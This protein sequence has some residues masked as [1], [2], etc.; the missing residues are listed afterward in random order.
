MYSFTCRDRVGI[1][2]PGKGDTALNI[3]LAYH[4]RHSC[5]IAGHPFSLRFQVGFN[6]QLAFPLGFVL[7]RESSTDLNDI[8]EAPIGGLWD[9]TGALN[10]APQPGSTVALLSVNS[11]GRVQ[12]T[13]RPKAYIFCYHHTN[14]AQRRFISSTL[15]CP[16]F[17]ASDY[18]PEHGSVHDEGDV[19]FVSLEDLGAAFRKVDPDYLVTMLR[20]EEGSRDEARRVWMALIGDGWTV[21]HHTQLLA[22]P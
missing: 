11:A 7:P 17:G 21:S 12:K 14:L 1:D 18:A 4:L 22:D 20:S 19:V 10:G 9:G 16:A 6:F 15:D 3:R 13:P 8:D 2:K 5:H